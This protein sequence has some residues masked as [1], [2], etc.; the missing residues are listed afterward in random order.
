MGV[1]RKLPAPRSKAHHG[2]VKGGVEIRGLGLLGRG[3][4]R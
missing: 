1:E 2:S 3:W 4:V